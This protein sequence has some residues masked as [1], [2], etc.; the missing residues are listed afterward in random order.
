MCCDSS[1]DISSYLKVQNFQN[2]IVKIQARELGMVAPDCKP[3]IGE[4]K[5]HRM[6]QG[7]P[8]PHREFQAG[9]GTSQ[10]LGGGKNVTGG[11]GDGRKEGCC[12]VLPSGQGMTSATV[13][14]WQLRCLR[15]VE[16][17]VS[18]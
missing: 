16:T 3:S 7:E 9:L 4:D 2:T 8:Q 15:G 14:S 11:G 13:N 18:Q 1:L 12:D 10:E 5:A 17:G 6:R